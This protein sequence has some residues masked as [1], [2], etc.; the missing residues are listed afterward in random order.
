MIT[1]TRLHPLLNNTELPAPLRRPLRFGDPE[2]IRALYE[3]EALFESLD[4]EVD[5]ALADGVAPETLRRYR[6]EVEGTMAER[7][8][9]V[10]SSEAEAR[11]VAVHRFGAEYGAWSFDSVEAETVGGARPVVGRRPC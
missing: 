3:V 9:V 11:R 8:D 5:A 6:V 2:Q 7:Y 10:A 4:D 1:N